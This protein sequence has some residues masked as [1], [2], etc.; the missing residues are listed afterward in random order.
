MAGDSELAEI[1]KNYVPRSEYDSVLDAFN[2]LDGEHTKLKSQ[3]ESS[4]KHGDPAKHLERIK[5]LEG[6]VRSRS[7]RDQFD[8]LAK[9]LR[10]KPEFA[11]DI[12]DLA[13]FDMSKD[14]PDAKAM[15][16][17]L[18][19]W[20]EAKESRKNYL[21]GIRGRRRPGRRPGPGQRPLDCSPRR[22]DPKP[23][24]RV[25]DSGEGTGG[26][27]GNGQGGGRFRYSS[28]DLSNPEW[29]ARNGKAYAQAAQEGRLQKLG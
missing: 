1:L 23:R 6:K 11:E 18:K 19:D 4:S 28:T 8:K 12:F 20:L 17:H 25:D 5:E 26:R 22:A 21:D 14:E 16:K 2:E 10:I 7:H 13:K 3:L 9:E 24:L 29:M 27:G 15:G